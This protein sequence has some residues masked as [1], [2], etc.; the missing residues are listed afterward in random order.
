MKA[1]L[2]AVF[3]EMWK[4]HRNYFH[5]PAVYF[6]LILWPLL[7]LITIYYMYVPFLNSENTNST[8]NTSMG[9]L[10]L[11]LFLLIGFVGYSFFSS[12]IESAWR[13]TDERYQGT[14][15]MILLTPASRFSII[16]GNALSS[17]F[18]SV[19]LVT[20]LFVGV[21]ALYPGKLIINIPLFIYGMVLLVVSSVA[22]G[23]LLNSF[24][25]IT[26]DAGVAFVVLQ[27]PT[28]FFSG[29]RF[30]VSL[31]SNWMRLISY[32]I[33]LTYCLTILRSAFAQS[34]SFG[35]LEVYTA[36]LGVLVILMFYLSSRILVIAE[37][38]AKTDGSLTLF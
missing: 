11:E 17:L 4:Q 7:E 16:L 21:L 33:P 6:S 5:S 2:R 31:F 27:E 22:W 29:V 28:N 37:R 20:V 18:E 25:L 13:F 26:R 32:L 36:V 19:W 3:A 34:L 10:P 9:N 35:Q 23:T 24:F 15:E 8:Q 30:P 12:L 38:H 14:L 1:F